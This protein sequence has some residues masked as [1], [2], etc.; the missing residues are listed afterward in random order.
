MDNCEL[1]EIFPFH[2]YG[3]KIS[4]LSSYV[5]VYFGACMTVGCVKSARNLYILNFYI[6]LLA[7]YFS[8]AR[9]VI[10]CLWDDVG[11]SQKVLVIFSHLN[12]H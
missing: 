3:P 1:T 9:R 8:S 7:V 2:S 11:D 5:L 4:S 10:W 12:T 6:F